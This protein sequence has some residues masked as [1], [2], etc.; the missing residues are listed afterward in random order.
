MR[1]SD[2]HGHKHVSMHWNP[3]CV[4]T[5][6]NCGCIHTIITTKRE[7]HELF[8]SFLHVQGAHIHQPTCELSVVR[9]HVGKKHRHTVKMCV[10]TCYYIWEVIEM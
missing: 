3:K 9:V 10:Q 2:V 4:C 8:Q 7:T 5:Y 6:S 1:T